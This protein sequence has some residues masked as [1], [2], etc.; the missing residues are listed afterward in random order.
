MSEN[1]R[2]EHLQGTAGIP[3]YNRIASITRKMLYVWKQVL[4]KVKGSV[5]HDRTCYGL[6][7]TTLSPW[8]I[9]VANQQK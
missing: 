2:V 3:L 6:V 8:H 5:W 7:D 9:V 4:E 1:G